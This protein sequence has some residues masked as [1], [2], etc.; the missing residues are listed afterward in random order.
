MKLGKR[1]AVYDKR[2]LKFSLYRTKAALPKHPAHFGHDKLV[3]LPWGMLG[4]DKFGD[5]VFAGAA[6]ETMIWTAEGGK[7]VGFDDPGVLAAYSAVTG[8]NPADPNSDQ[9]TLTR[10]ALNYR[11]KVGLLD[12]HGVRHKIGAYV[13]LE[14]GNFDQLLEAVWL[15]G[16]S[17]VGLRFPNSAMDQFNAGQAWSVVAGASVE[18][19]HYV[20]FVNDHACVTWAKL[21][22]ATKPFYVKYC[23]EAYAILSVEMFRNG[24]TLEGFDLTALQADLKAL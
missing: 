4:N 16:A 14:P 1:E 13:A 21:Q 12:V 7:P 23:D 20:P 3:T 18:G 19:G 10:Q 2:D 15:F 6:H 17:A 22:S 9:G 8:F 11:R 5:C 24:K